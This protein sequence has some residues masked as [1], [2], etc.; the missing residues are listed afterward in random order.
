[1]YTIKYIP[2]LI[3]LFDR[4]SYYF[5]DSHLWGLYYLYFSDHCLLK[6]IHSLHINWFL[7]L[8]LFIKSLCGCQSGALMSMNNHWV[9]VTPN[10]SKEPAWHFSQLVQIN[11]SSVSIRLPI[12]LKVMYKSP[13]LT[14]GTPI[15]TT[16]SLLVL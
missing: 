11:K 9:I 15:G 16:L 3:Y 14:L 10:K 5:Y 4:Q 13:L 8:S 1:M 2:G 12:I 6:K 7:S